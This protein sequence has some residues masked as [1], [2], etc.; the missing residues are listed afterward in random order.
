M[1][2][3]SIESLGK[4]PFFLDE[5]LVDAQRNTLSINDSVQTVAPKVMQVLL[6]LAANNGNVVSQEALY[7]EVWPNS[8]FSPGSIRR[9]I[10]ILRKV[11]SK[12]NQELIKTF[13]KKGYSLNAKI[14]LENH[15]KTGFGNRVY[16]ALSIIPIIALLF[17]FTFTTETD[18]TFTV[19]E[20]TPIT[21][22]EALEFNAKISPDGAMVAFFR[23]AET[24][25]GNRALWVKDIATDEEQIIVDDNVLEFD[26]SI[27]ADALAFT[28]FSNKSEQ[29]QSVNLNTLNIYNS[30]T[31]FVDE[32]RISSMHWGRDNNLYTLTKENG[33][34]SLMTINLNSGK[35]SKLKDFDET[36]V[37][38]EIN[39]HK[40]QNKLAFAGFDQDGVSKIFSLSLSSDVEALSEIITLNKNRYFLAWH[41]NGEAMVIS[42]GRLLSTVWMDGSSSRINYDSYDFV[43]HPQFTPSGDQILF[44]LT[45]I[46]TDIEQM[47]LTSNDQ[48][49]KLVNSN[50]VDREPSLSPDK[51]KLAFISQRKGFPQVYVLD[52]TTQ[53][54]QLV[55]ENKERLL[56][57]S[58]PVW[59]ASN[60]R[61]GFSNY[62]FPIIISAE[63]DKYSVKQLTAP[64]GVLVD[65]YPNNEKVL[66]LARKSNQLST[67]D[68]A[69]EK[70]LNQPTL[71]A[72]NAIVDADGQV[73]FVQAN[74]LQCFQNDTE[75]EVLDLQGHVLS[76][77]KSGTELLFTLQ[78]DERNS[79][80]VV[81]LKSKSI[82]A[83]YGI[84]GF[85]T[86]VTAIKDGK[87]IY[88][89]Q[90]KQKDI[91]LLK[92]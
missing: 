76:W 5:F 78:A 89:S 43:Q 10:T 30:I 58:R 14:R 33:L 1:S 50:T 20:A 73:C 21:S 24:G 57:V 67:I 87:I 55:Y 3:F 52:L 70:T 47:S 85:V 23:I 92:S 65:F 69:T 86:K 25:E 8:V 79:L 62:D 45:K 82:N 12:E 56:G 40:V 75:F 63:N 91:V 26:W 39:L 84:P 46:D 37:P 4:T 71:N 81:D 80:V 51:S 53:E 11:L 61:L 27:E 16:W 41:P 54:I 44:S 68:L 2:D 28:T 74:K 6:V 38:Y 42:D 17:V 9:V 7:A 77:V 22:T 31:S 34:V 59:N 36:F 60:N 72:S 35:K 32:K 15:T 48:V 88:E 66:T 49:T 29:I 83:E 13:P 90:N 19:H 18:S 64:H